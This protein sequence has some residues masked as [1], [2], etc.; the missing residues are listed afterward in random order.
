MYPFS[1]GRVKRSV[2][3]LAIGETETA[4][5]FSKPVAVFVCSEI[6]LLID[7]VQVTPLFT[8][9]GH[10][11]TLLWSLC[12][13]GEA[14]LLHLVAVIEAFLTRSLGFSR[15]ASGA[16]RRGASQVLVI[17]GLLA[18]GVKPTLLDARVL[19]VDTTV[20]VSPG[21]AIQGQEN[22]TANQERERD[23]FTEQPV[24]ESF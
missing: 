3:S 20:L 14:I 21:S 12:S 19:L 24:R 18:S 1:A 9:V 17:A 10:K 15:P 4:T 2:A 22:Q 5:D 11:R 16:A 8:P 13:G 7:A 23:E 6:D